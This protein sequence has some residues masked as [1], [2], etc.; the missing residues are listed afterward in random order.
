MTRKV[1]GG[2]I[3]FEEAVPMK[4]EKLQESLQLTYSTSAG[5]DSFVLGSAHPAPAG[6]PSYL[7]TP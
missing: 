1:E 3:Y 6:L 5:K 4:A 2:I 7:V